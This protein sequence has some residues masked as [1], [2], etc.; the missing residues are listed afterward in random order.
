MRFQNIVVLRQQDSILK[1]TILNFTVTMVGSRH[2]R[3]AMLQAWR[4]G[5]F[6][7]FLTFPAI[8]NAQETIRY[9]YDAKGRVVQAIR[10]GGPSSGTTT[11]Y[12]YDS[13]DNRR[14]VKVEN[15]PNGNGSD[16]GTS[17]SSKTSLI[18]VVPLNGLSLIVINK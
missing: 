5:I 3:V 7:I 8:A 9:T 1:V 12:D 4:A 2:E 13:G 10:D 6:A 14:T 16:S 11:K 15:S 18:I 17:A